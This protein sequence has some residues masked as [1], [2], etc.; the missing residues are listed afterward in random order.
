LKYQIGDKIIVLHSE[1]EGHVVE[2][3][4]DKMVMIEV[5]GVQFP[6]Y[7][8]QIDFPYFKLFSQ[9]KKTIQKPKR[10]V[11]QIRTE[12]PVARKKERD[13]L[14]LDVFPVY[15]KDVFG[16]ELVDRLKLYLVN[17]NTDHYRV[18]YTYSIGGE[19]KV[20]FVAQVRGLSDLYL[21][22]VDFEDLND[23][24]VLGFEI[25]LEKPDKNKAPYVERLLKWRGK[26]LF[27]KIETLQADNKPSFSEEL[28][29]V[30]PDRIKED[31]VDMTMLTKAGFKVYAASEVRE[32]L[33][34]AR[35]VVDLHIEKL[36]DQPQQLRADEKLQLQ[37]DTAANYLELAL[38]HQLEKIIFIH[39]IGEGILRDA[40]HEQLKA[41]RHVSS[42][43]NQYHPTFGYGATEV[44]LK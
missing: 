5:R 32:H 42:V 41:H 25:S 27:K 23:N 3:I 34:P 21:H 44:Y 19:K 2:I 29:S 43:I 28:F 12:K 10:Y 35:S 37:L 15:D 24:P 11:D 13:G 26:Q 22:D 4:N 8:D 9:K 16:D 40:L 36:T 6:A 18:A 1:E 31:K 38:S 14:L 17:H 33:P 30:Y 7:M 20:A 39:G